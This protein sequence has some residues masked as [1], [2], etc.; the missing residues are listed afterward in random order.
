MNIYLPTIIVIAFDQTSKILI[1]KNLAIW[2]SWDIIGSFLR[3]TH[4]KN[5]GLAFGISVGD[6]KLLV[7][8]LSIIATI[9]IA[10][11]HWKER[12]NHPLIVNSLGLILGGAIGNII[13]R[14]FIFFTENYSGVVD[15]I[16]IGVGNF[17]W[18][19]FNIADCAV[20]I[21]VVLY[22]L[23]SLFIIKPKLIKYND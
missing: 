22:L 23:H 8:L 13:D 6:Y 4:V 9:F 5:P 17:R 11:L 7:T 16:D 18:Y 15:F 14:S 10:Y 1:K 20:T 2:E 3:V 12:N 19:T 21:G